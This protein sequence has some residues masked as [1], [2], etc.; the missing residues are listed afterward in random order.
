M[1]AQPHHLHSILMLAMARRPRL[2]GTLGIHHLLR[3][4][5]ILA[6]HPNSRHIHN[7]PPP[8]L[9]LLGILG[10]GHSLLQILT[11]RPSRLPMVPNMAQLLLMP[12]PARGRSCKMEMDAP[13]TITRPLE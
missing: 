11:L 2:Q 6:I 13:T 8:L 5:H 4:E 7:L 12:H 3:M 1:E 9:L 10:M